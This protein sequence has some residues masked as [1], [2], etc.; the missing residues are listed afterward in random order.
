MSAKMTTV[1]SASADAITGERL[2]F[3]E[4][5]LD[6]GIPNK[7]QPCMGNSRTRLVKESTIVWLAEQAGYDVV[8]R[9]ARD[10]GDAKVVDG[11]DVSVGGGA[12]SVGEVEAGG[13]KPAKRRSAGASKGK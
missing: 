1:R 9:D 7:K 11:E 8:K 10:S 4:P 3:T 12:P 13:G 6:T 2:S 5:V